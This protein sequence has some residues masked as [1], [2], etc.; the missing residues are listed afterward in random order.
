M[1][2]I[3]FELLLFQSTVNSRCSVSCTTQRQV[4]FIRLNQWR[5]L[6]D[7]RAVYVLVS[8]AWMRVQAPVKEVKV[9]FTI[10]SHFTRGKWR[11]E[12][13][14]PLRDRVIGSRDTDQR[15]GFQ[16]DL[17]TLQVQEVICLHLL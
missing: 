6:G 2:G 14:I 4:K 13:L 12:F 16:K 1:S 10:F 8:C 5:S 17:H 3:S 11:N 15:S 7:S 9:Y